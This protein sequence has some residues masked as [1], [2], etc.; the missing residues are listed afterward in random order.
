MFAFLNVIPDQTISKPD[1]LPF[2]ETCILER[3]RVTYC[4]ARTT[5]LTGDHP[6]DDSIGDVRVV[7]PQPFYG[8]GGSHALQS[9][10]CFSSGHVRRVRHDLHR[11]EYVRASDAPHSR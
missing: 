7:P 8:S 3:W 5:L 2:G 6:H 11:M 4:E 10:Q 9:R 1:G